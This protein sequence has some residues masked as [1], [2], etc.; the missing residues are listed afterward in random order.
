[1]A[2]GMLKVSDMVNEEDADKVRR[3]LNEVWGVR[4]IEISLARKEATFTYNDQSAS[5][6]DMVQAVTEQGYRAE[7]MEP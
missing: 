1:M 4:E 5:C 7:M 6:H 2:K 3:A